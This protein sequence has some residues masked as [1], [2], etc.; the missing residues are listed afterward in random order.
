MRLFVG[1]R[2][3]AQVREVLASVLRYEDPAFRW[4]SPAQWHVTLR[5]FGAVA[6][7]EVAPLVAALAGVAA[8]EPAREVRLGPSTSRLG[9]GNLVVP[10]TGL[11]EL[12]AEVE[13]AT[14]DVGRPPSGRPFTG[15]LTLARGRGRRG[16]PARAVGHLLSATWH[17]DDFALVRSRLH[18]DGAS[19]EDLASFPLGRS[20]PS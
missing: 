19:Y 18:P 1:L 8:A 16:V 11:D 2:P 5:F 4:T 15:H 12:G 3:P 6:D 9:R 20:R 7:H 10:V 17:V 13:A 14:A